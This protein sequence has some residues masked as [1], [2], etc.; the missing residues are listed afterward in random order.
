MLKFQFVRPSN[1]SEATSLSINFN[2]E[3]FI[4]LF[5]YLMKNNLVTYRSQPGEDKHLT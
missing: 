3:I 5:L 4:V 2:T 1:A